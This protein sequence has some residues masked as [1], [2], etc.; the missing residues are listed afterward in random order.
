MPNSQMKKVKGFLVNPLSR[1]QECLLPEAPSFAS[2]AS[3]ARRGIAPRHLDES[4]RA[5][6]AARIANMTRGGDRSK[7][8]IDALKSQ[9]SAAEQ[10]AASRGSVQRAA[11][12]IRRGIA[13]TC[14]RK[15]TAPK[16]RDPAPA[17]PTSKS[18]KTIRKP[19]KERVRGRFYDPRNR[20]P[21]AAAPDNQSAAKAH[22]S[23]V[24]A[25]VGAV[26]APER[27]PR[28]RRASQTY[29]H[30]MSVIRATTSPTTASAPRP[31]PSGH[32]G[33]EN[34][35]A[36]PRAAVGRSIN[37]GRRGE[38][39]N[40]R[41]SVA[42]TN[43]AIRHRKRPNATRASVHLWVPGGRG[44]RG[45]PSRGGHH[46]ALLAEVRNDAT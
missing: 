18:R 13:P 24:I 37:P 25:S 6:V 27:A 43:P 9:T 44:R 30:I 17:A 16:T 11:S 31:R 14:A 35:V 2:P 23:R 41:I 29:G 26:I 38:R 19:H 28:H 7:A 45:A 4:Q 20:L 3:P 21:C 46:G 22:D 12:V 34:A 39:K 15:P 1:A 5:M 32:R 42:G 40:E 10:C 8:S 36:P 33:R